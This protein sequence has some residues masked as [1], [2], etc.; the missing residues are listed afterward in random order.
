MRVPD[1]SFIVLAVIL[2]ANKTQGFVNM[3]SLTMQNTQL[4]YV[5]SRNLGFCRR[6]VRFTVTRFGSFSDDSEEGMPPFDTEKHLSRVDCH[7][8]EKG[9]LRSAV[10]SNA[11][12]AVQ[13]IRDVMGV[14]IVT[15]ILGFLVLASSTANFLLGD[16]WLGDTFR[17]GSHAALAPHVS[18]VVP[19]FALPTGYSMPDTFALIKNIPE[20]DLQYVLQGSGDR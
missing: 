11:P 15:Y 4:G 5:T 7:Q 19:K 14:N 10:E 2:L 1:H 16:G 9:D 13:L 6:V 3:P 12:S 8:A 20:S 18:P 17:R